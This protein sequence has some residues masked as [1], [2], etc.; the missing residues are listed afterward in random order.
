MI[1][2]E[3]DRSPA[4]LDRS[5]VSATTRR[6]AAAAASASPSREPQQRPAGLWLRAEAAR[7]TVRLFRLFELAAQTMNLASEV[8]SLRRGRLV[9]RFLEAPAGALH[10]LQRLGPLTVKL[11]EL[12]AV[13]E[14]AAGEGKQVGLPL[15][16]ARQGVRPLLG[17][18]DLVDLLAGEDHAA[19]DDTGDDRMHLSRRNR[20][21]C[22]VE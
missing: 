2:A 22:L 8:R 14:A 17:P 6:I 16:P 19:V 20:H 9:H 10:L 21:H 7:F 1:S 12:G 18:P 11:H 4:R 3:A 5:D 15:P 13:H